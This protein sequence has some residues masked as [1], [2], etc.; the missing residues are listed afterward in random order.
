MYFQENNFKL[1]CKF[2]K[3]VQKDSLNFYSRISSE[4]C[5]QVFFKLWWELKKKKKNKEKNSG[6]ADSRKTLGWSQCMLLWIRNNI[7]PRMN[8]RAH[9]CNILSLV[10]NF[11]VAVGIC[12]HE[13]P[14]PVTDDDYG[15]QLDQ[16]SLASTTIIIKM[17]V[18]NMVQWYY[19]LYDN[20]ISNLQVRRVPLESMRKEHSFCLENLLVS[21]YS[22]CLVKF[23]SIMT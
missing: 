19:F 15:K 6:Y 7:V 14:F 8:S 21:C 22:H 3:V 17:K 12:S 2:K 4:L 18:N 20:A 5:G 10:H 1:N 13:I 23:L 11:K 9:S 16:K